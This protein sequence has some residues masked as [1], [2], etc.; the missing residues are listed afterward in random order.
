MPIS[1]P[2]PCAIDWRAL[3]ILTFEFVVETSPFHRSNV[4]RTYQAI[5]REE[6][7]YRTMDLT[8]VNFI[9][10]LPGKNSYERMVW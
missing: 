2:T 5:L 4:A 10:R 1:P 7:R 9:S 6:L 3:G 8:T